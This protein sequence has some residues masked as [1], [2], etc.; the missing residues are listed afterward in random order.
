VAVRTFKSLAAPPT[1]FAVQVE[2]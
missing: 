2:P 1:D